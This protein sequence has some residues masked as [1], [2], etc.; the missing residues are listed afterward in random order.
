MTEPTSTAIFT[1]GPWATL[2]DG[3]DSNDALGAVLTALEHDKRALAPVV[4]YDIPSRC[5]D[6]LFQVSSVAASLDA[7][8]TDAIDIFDTALATAHAG[9]ATRGISIVEGDDPDQLP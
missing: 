5:I 3:V 8:T 1:A 2:P 9:T 7:A 6:A 4:S